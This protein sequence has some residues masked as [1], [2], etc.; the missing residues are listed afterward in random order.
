MLGYLYYSFVGLS[1]CF[2][3][4]EDIN[5]IDKFVGTWNKQNS[6]LWHIL[7]EFDV[8]F[9]FTDRSFTSSENAN[10]TYSLSADGFVLT[11]N[12]GNDVWSF[13]YLFSD[14]D[15]RLTLI[16]SSEKAALYLKQ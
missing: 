3:S 16:D 1:G 6:E 2:G 11:F 7:T 12:E 5:E 10:G 4:E 8:I 13:S 9:F 14:S 15:Q